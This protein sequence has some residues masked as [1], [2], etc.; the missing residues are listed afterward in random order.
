MAGQGLILAT[1]AIEYPPEYAAMTDTAL[2]QLGISKVL[3][4]TSTYDHR[5]I[6]GPSQGSFWRTFTNCCL[7]STTFTMK[8]LPIL[9]LPIDRSAGR[10]MPIRSFRGRS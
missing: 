9:A 10:P 8:Y 1:G 4:I 5:I 3:T 7:E 6:Q 2:S